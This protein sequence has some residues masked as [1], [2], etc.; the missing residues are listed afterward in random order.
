MFLGLGKIFGAAKL[1]VFP[2]APVA[3]ALVFVDRLLPVWLL[4]HCLLLFVRRGAGASR[5][6]AIFLGRGG[7]AR[8][9][10]FTP[11]VAACP[12][13]DVPDCA[14]RHSR[15]ASPSLQNQGRYGQEVR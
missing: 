13:Y 7:D 11:F 12:R 3:P 14:C 15:S 9:M 2:I 4:R 6:G 5:H 8:D 10:L 1:H